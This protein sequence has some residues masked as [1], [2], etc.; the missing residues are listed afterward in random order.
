[1]SSNGKRMSTAIFIVVTAALVFL[2]LS[3]SRGDIGDAEAQALVK[4]GATL[5][6]VRTPS[7]FSG[8]H[9]DG[10]LN[11]PVDAIADRLDEVPRDKAVVVYCRSGMRSARAAG[12]LKSEGYERVHNVGA[13]PSW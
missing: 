13:M 4:D 3:R 11:I 7:E 5:L 8:G 2:M 9:V 1:M 10:A 12:I 6:D